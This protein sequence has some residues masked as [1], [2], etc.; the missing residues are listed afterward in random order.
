MKNIFLTLR[1]RCTNELDT[2]YEELHC[3]AIKIK[4][5]EICHVVELCHYLMGQGKLVSYK[6]YKVET[7]PFACDNALARP[8]F[9]EY[10]WISAWA[11]Q[12]WE[13]LSH[14]AL[15][16]KY[17][18][19]R[20]RQRSPLLVSVCIFV[21]VFMYKVSVYTGPTHLNIL[22]VSWY[23]WS[24]LRQCPCLCF[25]STWSEKSDVGISHYTSI[26]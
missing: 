9:G 10:W 20:H 11:T 1:S 4:W 2:K 17:Q 15:P 3:S 23:Q 13:Q 26:T 24:C 6:Q 21:H 8:Q 5:Q 22:L 7:A 16:T 25:S 14:N 12:G 18:A 19:D